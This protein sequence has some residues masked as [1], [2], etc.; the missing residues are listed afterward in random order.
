MKVSIIMQSYLGQYLGSRSN[1]DI[2]FLRAVNS[3]IEQDD[4]ESELIIVSD[5][6]MITHD[7]YYKNFKTNDRVKYVY[8]DKDTL[9]MY[10][11]Y[12]GSRFY[13]GFP[14]EVG[15]ALVT[16]DITTYMDSDD[17]LLPNHISEI[18]LNWIKYSNIDWLINTSWYDNIHRFYNPID[19]Y[20]NTII[21]P[22]ESDIVD[23]DGLPS[24]WLPYRNILNNE[25]VYIPMQPWTLCHSS[26]VSVKW[27]DTV[28]TSED[29][30]FNK[31]LRSLYNG[32]N[33]YN[34]PT[35]VRCHYS[36]RWDF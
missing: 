14:R 4:K 18:K 2:K 20:N 11:N 21:I 33:F 9:N 10:D 31:Q 13:R 22:L 3:F 6:C 1:S 16:G 26:N 35:Y 24:K 19:E 15:R 34:T 8:V 27:V 17:F 12:S 28:D 23:I 32:D 36:N 7:L 30:T 29:I 5:G 25:I